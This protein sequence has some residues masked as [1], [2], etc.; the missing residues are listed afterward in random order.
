ME[1]THIFT[2]AGSNVLV[3]LGPNIYGQPYNK[4]Q[5]DALAEQLKKAFPDAGEVVITQANI[6]TILVTDKDA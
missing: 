4:E 5:T 2:H 1:V 6:E 3:K